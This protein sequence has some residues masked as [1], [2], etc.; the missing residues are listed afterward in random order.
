MAI[1]RGL[2]CCGNGNL[3]AILNRRFGCFSSLGST[4]TKNSGSVVIS[5]FGYGC[6]V[7]NLGCWREPQSSCLSCCTVRVRM[8]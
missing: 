3:S 7:G 6:W 2:L 4:N 1:K 8:G 5:V